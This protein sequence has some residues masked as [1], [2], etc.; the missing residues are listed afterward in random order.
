MWQSGCCSCNWNK[1]SGFFVNLLMSSAILE[2][3]FLVLSPYYNDGTTD[4]V[5]FRM[6]RMSDDD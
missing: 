6:A 5:T 3:L 4:G 1:D 2:I